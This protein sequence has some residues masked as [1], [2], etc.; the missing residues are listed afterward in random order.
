M[1]DAIYLDNA[2]TTPIDPL[3]RAAISPWIDGEFGN[4]SSRHRHGERARA[5][6]DEARGRVARAVGAAR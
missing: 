1:S 4:P 2:A 3:V 6:I 5:A